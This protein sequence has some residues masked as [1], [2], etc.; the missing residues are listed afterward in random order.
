MKDTTKDA[1]L[2]VLEGMREIALA[3]MMDRV[4]YL[5]DDVVDRSRTGAVCRGHKAC[6][7]GSLWLAAGVELKRDIY[8]DWAL[9]GVEEDEREEFVRHRAKLRIA[10]RALNEAATEYIERHG[11][12]RAAF[13]DPVEGLFE[14]HDRRMDGVNRRR[15]M[16]QVIATAKRKVRTY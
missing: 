4:G 10:L 12:R 11:I 5:S 8:G 3:D 14:S 15:V 16:L 13:D 6:A 7:V 9:P 2:D 1:A